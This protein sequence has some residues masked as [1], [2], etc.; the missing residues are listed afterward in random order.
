MKRLFVF[1][2]LI[3]GALLFSD[4]AQERV[5]PPSKVKGDLRVEGSVAVGTSASPDASAAV[6][7][8]ST[9]KGLLPPRMTTTQRDAISSPATGLLIFNTTTSTLQRYN[10]AAWADIG[11]GAATY[12]L[13]DGTQD[14]EMTGPFSVEVAGI[15]ATF[16][17]DTDAA[18]NVVLKLVT[19]RATPANG[20]AAILEVWADDT[21]G[22]SQLYAQIEGAVEDIGGKASN[23][24]GS[25]DFKVEVGGAMTS[26]LKLDGKT[27]TATLALNLNITGTPGNITAG[28]L[29]K[30]TAAAG[31]G[32]E[33][34]LGGYGF[35]ADSSALMYLLAE[36]SGG[37]YTLV[38]TEIGAG[39]SLVELTSATHPTAP[40]EFQA[41]GFTKVLLG[42]D[43]QLGGS[44][45]TVSIPG[46]LGVGVVSPDA[47]AIF[48][49][50]STTQ[51]ILPPRMTTAQRDLIGSPATGLII[52]NTDTNTVQR[53]NGAAWATIGSGVYVLKSGDVMTGG[54][55]IF[56]AGTPA[57]LENTTDAA[58]N[59]A[60]TLITDRATPANGDAAILEFRADDTG[61]T[62][63]LYAQLEGAV[64]DIGGAA[65]NR[66]GSLD[67]KVRVDDVMTSFLKLDGATEIAT[68]RAGIHTY[69]NATTINYDSTIVFDATGQ[70]PEMKATTWDFTGSTN[71]I[72]PDAN[73]VT[74]AM[75]QQTSD[76][77]YI[78]DSEKGAANGVATLSAGTLVVEDPANATATP[79]ASKI[80]IA[81]GSGLL[82]GWVTYNPGGT[83]VAIA[84]GGTGAGTATAGFDA[85]SPLSTKGDI[86][87]YSTTNVRVPVGTNDQVLTADST[88][89]AGVKWANAPGTTLIDV[90]FGGDTTA[91]FTSTSTSYVQ[92]GV[93][94]FGGTTALGTPTNIRAIGAKDASP[95]SWDVRIFDLTNALEIA[96]A[97]GNTGTVAELV[98]MGALSNL[99]AGEAMWEVQL[100]RTGGTGGSEIHVHSI[101]VVF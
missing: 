14:P 81:D 13:R 34:P 35:T 11:G 80:P 17:N 19:D 29:I 98:D 62:E 58:S 67:F 69:P 66:D 95:T 2:F 99:S 27:G 60:L 91:S 42:D 38:I 70:S 63:R 36:P 28:G 1:S 15:P 40:N 31:A 50:D 33:A 21:T 10:G 71:I 16:E 32:F 22:T 56:V 83:D 45:D 72:I 59:V 73:A 30:T 9:T 64:E 12:V 6:D 53:Y 101:S 68:Y 96:E 3:F 23:R 25:W 7:I 94:R 24:D 41:T 49:A 39:T 76:A 37:G 87:A 61:G 85:L 55:S 92:A 65:S 78:E 54:I 18:S 88:K 4:P 51:G 44:G 90:M 43:V 26:L 46:V 75:N 82:D 86:L 47:S 8:V 100:K 89:T 97:T 77:R 52:Y 5:I 20:D 93:F 79:T 48:Q 74:E 84:D 57:F